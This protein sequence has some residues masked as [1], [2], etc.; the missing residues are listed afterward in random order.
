MFRL[1]PALWPT[2]FSLPVFILCMG[3]ALWQMERREWKRDILDRIAANQ[4]ATPVTLDE[5]LKG[6]PLVHEYGRARI[7]GTFLHDKEFF[8]AARS[9]KDDVGMHVVTPVRTQDGRIVLLDRG[10]IPSTKKDPATRAAG[11]VAGPV[12]LVGVVRRTQER[13]QFAPDND[14]AKNFW[15][16][17]DVPLMRKM[18][19]GNPDPK[20]DAFFLEAD[21]TPNP[22]GLPIGGQTRLDIPNDHL[23]YA[24]T[25]FLIGMALVGVYLAYHWEN[26]RLTINGRSKGMA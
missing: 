12:D 20:L 18:A 23:Q 7:S 22:G 9:L 26:G 17:V 5:L 3:L 24:I 25:W 1:R 13:R 15:F 6:D 16:H 11:Q 14:P 21:A 4:A 2:V 8:L 10:W 19:G